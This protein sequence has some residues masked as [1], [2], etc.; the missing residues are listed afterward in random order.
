MKVLA[1][2]RASQAVLFEASIIPAIVGTATAVRAGARFDA[3][4]FGLIVLS[5]VGIQAGANLFKGFYEGRDRSA[6][7]SSPG[8]WFAFDSAAATNLTAR[9][10]D[11][12][13]IGRLCFAI[14]VGA[15][16]LLVVLTRNAV[17]LAFG[18]A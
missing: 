5:L 17:L 10:E 8:S 11:V 14:G 2:I 6:P 4:W 13:R 12:L 16:L 7:P 9:P 3:V 15:G 18:V 1:W